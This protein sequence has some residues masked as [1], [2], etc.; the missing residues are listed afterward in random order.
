MY[1]PL[2]LTGYHCANFTISVIVFAAL[3]ITYLSKYFRSTNPT[4][5][6]IP[7]AIYA[8]AEANASAITATTPLLKAF[9]LKF[10]YDTTAP[11]IPKPPAVLSTAAN[12]I[13]ENTLGSRTG[14]NLSEHEKPTTAASSSGGGARPGTGDNPLLV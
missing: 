8:L 9:I 4:Y 12:H 11:V 10:T 1:V 13:Q 6:G 14:S 3:R 2:P 5:S 7:T